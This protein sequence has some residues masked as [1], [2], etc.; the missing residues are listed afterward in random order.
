MDP[1][2]ENLKAGAVPVKGGVVPY[3][4]IDGAMKAAE[5]YA[6]ALGAETAAAIPPDDKG[7]TMH[8]HLYVNGSSIMMS[9]PYPEYGHALEKPQGY[10][11]V[12]QVTDIDAWWGRARAAGFEEVMP[13]QEMFWGARYGQLR[14]PFGVL[15]AMN[16][17]LGG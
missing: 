2:A 4:Q 15:W 5:L 11:L 16:Q 10:S 14:D 9:D 1:T 17:P 3:L 6:R 8:V 7:R 12:L 13:V